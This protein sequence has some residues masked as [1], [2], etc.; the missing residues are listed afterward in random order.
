M[1]ENTNIN[2]TESFLLSA[3]Y[4]SHTTNRKEYE[5]E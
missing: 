5:L 2:K 1:D 4:Y 3:T